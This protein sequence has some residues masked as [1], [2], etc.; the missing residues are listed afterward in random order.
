MIND[1]TIE[2]L[3]ECNQGIKM[4]VNSIDEVL[5][6]VNSESLRKRLEASRQEHEELGNETHRLLDQYGESGKDPSLMAKGMS[7]IKTNATMLANPTDNSAADIIVDGCDMGIKSLNKYKNQYK[8]A[9]EQ[10]KD[11]TDRLIRT[12]EHLSDDLRSFL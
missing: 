11:I 4:A 9:D 5:P 2:M 3:K 10:A 6:K 8:A 12:E 1:D 7:W